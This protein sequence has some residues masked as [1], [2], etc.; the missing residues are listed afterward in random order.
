MDGASSGSTVPPAM[1]D[2]GSLQAMTGRIHEVTG[3]VADGHFTSRVEIGN[4]DYLES[5]A[6][7]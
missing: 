6:M 3:L 1:D 5:E 4:C 2:H 7:T